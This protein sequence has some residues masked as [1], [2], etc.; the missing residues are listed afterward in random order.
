M[1]PFRRRPEPASMPLLLGTAL[2]LIAV[3]V[4]VVALFFAFSPLVPSFTGQCVAVVDLN[5]EIALEGSEPT[6]FTAGSPGSEEIAQSIRALGSRDDV[7]AVLFVVNS[8]GGSVVATR[9][10]YDAVKELDKPKVAYFREVAA[11]GAYYIATGTDYII[12]DPDAL[13]GSIGVVATFTDLSGLL[14]KIG[15]NVTSIASGAHKDMGSEF[16]NMTPEEQAIMQA[17][18]SEIYDE[19]HSVVLE[20]RRGRLDLARFEEV[21]DGRIMSGRQAAKIG[22]VDGVGSK[23]DAILKAA[24]LANI[25][26]GSADEVRLCQVSSMTQAGGLFSADA[27]ISQLEAKAGL[28]M[29]Y[30]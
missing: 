29:G 1:D 23:R 11:S 9:E 16:R 10:I 15:V 6:I 21:A 19:F 22:L 7:G 8:P 17:L 12:S 4:A 30:R 14:E 2:V 18:I 3:F 5:Q 28:A 26:A 25:S 24:S 20:N 27:L 13:T